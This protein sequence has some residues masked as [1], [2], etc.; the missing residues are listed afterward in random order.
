MVN[1]F[2][3]YGSMSVKELPLHRNIGMEIVYVSRGSLRWIVEDRTETVFPGSVFFT[4]PWQRH[5]SQAVHEPGNTI[6]FIQFRLDRIY[7]Q[8]IASFEFHPALRFPAGEDRR[9]SRVFTGASQHT[10]PATEDLSV[11]FSLLIRKLKKNAEP[12]VLQGLFQSLVSELAGIVSGDISGSIVLNPVE[13]RVKSFLDSLGDSCE[14]SWRL[15]AMAESCSI[16]RSLFAETVRKL[17]GDSPLEY[18][19]RLR[20]KCAENL[21]RDTDLNITDVALDCGFSTS[22]LFSRIFRG[23]THLT[24]SQYRRQSRLQKSQPSMDFTLKNEKER[25]EALTRHEWL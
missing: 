17:T 10:W 23:F 22:Q 25:F 20:V 1:G 15:E 2:V 24:P 3:T 7:R 4:L 9:I 21:L 18:L 12:L 5:G 11:F 8:P 19:R 16:G 14:K 13:L 6:H